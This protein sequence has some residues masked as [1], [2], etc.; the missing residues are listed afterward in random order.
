MG[1]ATNTIVCDVDLQFQ[2][3]WWPLKGKILAIFH[4][5]AQFSYTES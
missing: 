4:I 3:H 2:G 1:I 5:L